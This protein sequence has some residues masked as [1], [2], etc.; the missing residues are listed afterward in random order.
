MMAVKT[1]HSGDRLDVYAIVAPMIANVNVKFV[2]PRGFVLPTFRGKDCDWYVIEG[3]EDGYIFADERKK[4]KTLYTML[5]TDK[6]CASGMWG[7]LGTDH[8]VKLKLGDVPPQDFRNSILVNKSN[9]QSG[10]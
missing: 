8:D 5:G 2:L 6:C 3:D 4:I 10:A 7:E 1:R 9:F